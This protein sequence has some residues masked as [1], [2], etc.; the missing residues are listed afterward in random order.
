MDTI[1]TNIELSFLMTPEMDWKKYEIIF[2]F[3][4]FFYEFAGGNLERTLTVFYR[5]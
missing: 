2:M 5:I 1:P 4:F 3:F